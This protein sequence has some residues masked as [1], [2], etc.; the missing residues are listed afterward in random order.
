MGTTGT[1][2]S[3]PPPIYGLIDYLR[4]SGELKPN[5]TLSV[6]LNGQKLAERTITEKD[7]AN[8]LP[9]MLTAAAPQIHA[10][11]TK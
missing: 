1:P 5:Y 4:I 2:R 9:I 7:V 6:Y 10:G 3:R 11:R 8:P